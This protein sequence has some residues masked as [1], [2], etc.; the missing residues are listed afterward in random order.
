MSLERSRRLQAPTMNHHY[1]TVVAMQLTVL[2]GGGAYPTPERGC[3]GYLVEEADFRL[4]VDPGHA[5]LT[6]LLKVISARAVDAV[7]VSHGHADHCADLNPLLRARHL[8]EDPPA[9]LPVFALAG[10]L[11]AVLALDGQM[12][13]SDYV[14]NEFSAGDRFTVG[15]FLLNTRSLTHFVPNVGVRISAGQHSVA[16]T[17]DGGADPGVVEL[18]SGAQL[19]LA[20][21]TFPD[22]VPEA[23]RGSLANA[24]QAGEHATAAGVSQLVLTHLWPDTD[25]GAGEAAARRHFTGPV[26]VAVPGLRIYLS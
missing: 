1:V 17:G 2:G 22:N 15:P 26:A 10:A 14:M 21:A 7:F 16:Y 8:N 25:P 23:S 6:E 11:D 19:L 12:L 18:A 24:A 5:T 4:L 20:E 3:S 13:A 9:P